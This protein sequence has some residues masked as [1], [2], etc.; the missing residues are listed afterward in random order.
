MPTNE[1]SAPDISPLITRR[2]VA[3]RFN[4]CTRSIPR[5]TARIGFPRPIKINGRTYYS[6]DLINKWVL[7]RIGQ[8]SGEAS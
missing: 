3:K 5:W 4:C 2:E 1:F 8:T 7:A 6:E